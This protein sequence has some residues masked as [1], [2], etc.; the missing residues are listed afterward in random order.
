MLGESVYWVMHPSRRTHTWIFPRKGS[1]S[2]F[3]LVLK[4]MLS[5]QQI[6]YLRTASIFISQIFCAGCHQN[7]SKLFVSFQHKNM[8]HV[9]AAL[10][11]QSCQTGE[12]SSCWAPPESLL[13]CTA[14]KSHLSFCRRSE[15]NLAMLFI[16]SSPTD[17]ASPQD[18][19]SQALKTFDLGTAQGRMSVSYSLVST[20]FSSCFLL[21]SSTR[22]HLSKLNLHT[23]GFQSRSVLSSPEKTRSYHQKCLLARLQNHDC[24]NILA[25]AQPQDLHYMSDEDFQTPGY[26]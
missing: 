6:F 24:S 22:L 13:V 26:H 1:I 10:Q 12:T 14:H 21:S 2:P 18:P 8:G 17:P 16:I 5:P 15:R 25:I 7:S 19:N 9:N 23:I 20:L 11:T 3:F 4:T